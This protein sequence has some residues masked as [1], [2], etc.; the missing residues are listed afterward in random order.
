MRP[1]RRNTLS[2]IPRY[3]AYIGAFWSNK[4]RQL[5]GRKFIQNLSISLIFIAFTLRFFTDLSWV[6]YII[7]VGIPILLICV[8]L[9]SKP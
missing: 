9:S 3:N 8:L 7:V 5:D 2:V 1:C 4:M 6:V